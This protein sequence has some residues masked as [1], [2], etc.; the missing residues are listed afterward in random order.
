MTVSIITPVYNA[1][2]RLPRCLEALAAQTY[3]DLQIVLVDDGSTDG[4]PRLCDNAARADERIVVIHQENAGPPVARNAG[5]DAAGGR[6]VMF[7]DADDYIE[8]DYVQVLVGVAEE[9]EADLV[10][11]DCLMVEGGQARRFGH[12]IADKVYESRDALYEDFLAE[13]M[14][15]SLW[16]KLYDARL[17]E[18]VR[19]DPCDY[20]AEDLDV[21]ARI[22]AREGLRVATT[23]CTGY[24]YSVEEGSVDHSFTKRHLCQFDVFERVVRLVHEQGISTTTSVE[25]FYGERVLGCLRKALDAHALTPEIASAFKDAL[26]VHRNEVLADP[27]ASA[28]LKR[29]LRVA[30]LGPRIFGVFHRICS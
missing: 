23:A 13:R 12:V 3:E 27:A 14:P 10:V 24:H 9:R 2:D 4:T 8:P 11:S 20:I 29:R 25:S 6:W 18:G 28:S 30:S 16:G 15:W 26:S 5:L 22:F 7:V 1:Q 17:F 21:N 19:F